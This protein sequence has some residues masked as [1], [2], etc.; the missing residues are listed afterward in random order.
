M[1]LNE[2]S[3]PTDTLLY[4]QHHEKETTNTN[5]K[6]YMKYKLMEQDTDFSDTDFLIIRYLS[7][8]VAVPDHRKE[9]E[10]DSDSDDTD[11]VSNYNQNLANDQS[12]CHSVIDE[13]KN[14][15]LDHTKSSMLMLR[16][17]S[18]SIRKKQLMENT[19]RMQP[20]PNQYFIWWKVR[21]ALNKLL[22]PV[23]ENFKYDAK[24]APTLCK[25]ISS[26]CV[27]LIKRR[28]DYPR[29]RYV[30][31]VTLLQL[32]RQGIIVGDRSLWNSSV[33]NCAVCVFRNE[34]AV[35]VVTLHGIYLE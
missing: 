19:Y 24:I 14:F 33:D 17:H 3:L 35:C 1:L 15:L 18:S 11:D 8:N 26:K 4:R 21:N 25:T 6:H 16:R 32:R 23:F 20:K 22:S 13:H 27:N 10:S 2:W 5:T 28:F 12:N 30:C 29:Y 31:H 7:D 34:S 9:N